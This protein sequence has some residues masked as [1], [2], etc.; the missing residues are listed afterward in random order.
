MGVLAGGGVGVEAA[1]RGG[2]R[3][4]EVGG[5]R[6]EAAAGGVHWGLL[7]LLTLLRR[8]GSRAVR[9]CVVGRWG[10]ELHARNEGRFSGVPPRES[11]RLVES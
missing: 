10:D 3:R 7:L 9:G 5:D 8:H 4:A 11:C 2:R 1:A 6:A